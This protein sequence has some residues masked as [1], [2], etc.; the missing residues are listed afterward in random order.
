MCDETARP[1]R[2][3]WGKGPNRVMLRRRQ[4]QTGLR[5]A[6]ILLF[7]LFVA[8]G[9]FLAPLGHGGACSHLLLMGLKAASTLKLPASFVHP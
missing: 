2:V 5:K 9:S 6:K 8:H 3:F 4:V 1:L 7:A